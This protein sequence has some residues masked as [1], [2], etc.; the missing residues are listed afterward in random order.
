MKLLYRTVIRLAAALFPVMLLWGGLFYLNTV[1]AM[2]DDIDDRL[3]SFSESI[4]YL[5][6]AGKEMPDVLPSG[7]IYDIIPVNEDFARTI[8]HIHYYDSQQVFPSTGRD[9][10]RVLRIVFCDSNGSNYVFKAYTSTFE[11]DELIRSVTIWTM[12]LYLIMVLLMI[13]VSALV[14]YSNLKPLYRLLDWL[15]SY[16]AGQSNVRLENTTNVKEFERLNRSV[17]YA[18]DRF[19]AAY[20]AQ[21]DF[22][23]NA[24]HEL[25]TPLAVI[26][27]RIEWLLDNTELNEIQTGELISMQRTLTEAVRLNR[28]LLLLTKIENDQYTGSSEIDLACMVRESIGMYSEIFSNKNL[29]C[30]YNGPENQNQ[31]MD[32]SLTLSLV[33]NLLK[34]AFMYTREGGRIEVKV[35]PGFFSVSNDGDSPLDK[36]RIFQRFYKAG[37]ASGASGLGLAI[38]A[39]IAKSRNLDIQYEFKAKRHNFYVKGP[40]F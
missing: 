18:M 4:I 29:H 34:N 32:Y 39:A 10:A 22:I 38:V 9:N 36:N 2:Q 8:P 1:K 6:L 30:L 31:S 37:N 21:K 7:I 19:E 17:Q 5:F 16:K 15:D 40:E 11:K 26:G 24:S 14:F 28:D 27:N 20:N 23:G 35:A 13:S 12:V 3:E 33:N 25:Q